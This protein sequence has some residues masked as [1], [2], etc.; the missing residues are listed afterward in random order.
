M[1]SKWNQNK[2][3]PL[4][5]RR[6]EEKRKSGD[7]RSGGCGSFLVVIVVFCA[8][9]AQP[10]SSKSYLY[11]RTFFPFKKEKKGRAKSNGRNV[12][13]YF[14]GSKYKGRDR[15]GG[16]GGDLCNALQRLPAGRILNTFSLNDT[17]THTHTIKKKIIIISKGSYLNP[18]ARVFFLFVRFLGTFLCT[19]ALVDVG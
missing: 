14:V 8:I 6:E 12:F 17:H 19:C 7:R 4:K 18:D 13:Q 11:V 3:K 2:I 1:T 15:L 5:K 9:E 10:Q 16:R